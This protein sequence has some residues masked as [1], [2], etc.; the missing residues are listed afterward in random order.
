MNSVF[1]ANGN[2]VMIGTWE[3]RGEHHKF[4]DKK[5]SSRRAVGTTTKGI[6]ADKNR[7]GNLGQRERQKRKERTRIREQQSKKTKPTKSYLAA[8]SPPPPQ[9]ELPL[10]PQKPQLVGR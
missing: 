8:P 2:L 10:K 3:P 9:P 4:K 6:K 5:T 1:P 7:G